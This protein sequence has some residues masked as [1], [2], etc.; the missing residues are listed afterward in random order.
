[1]NTKDNWQTTIT[2]HDEVRAAVWGAI[3]PGARVPVRTL[4]PVLADLPGIRS[5][6]VYFLDLD[7]V[8]DA[9]LAELVRKLAELFSLDPDEV[10]QDMAATGVPILAD[11]TSLESS[12]H[13]LVQDLIGDLDEI[14]MMEAAEMA[15]LEEI[16][17]SLAGVD[18]WSGKELEI[19]E[20]GGDDE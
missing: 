16:D 10:R 9:Q 12:D 17:P 11:N 7:A 3:F 14:E 18:D 15:G 20:D 8:S 2:I 6:R 5:A 4:V 19:D 1:M 13:A